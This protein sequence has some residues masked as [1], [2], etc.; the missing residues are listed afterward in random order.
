MEPNAGRIEEYR[1]LRAE[2]GA[3]DRLMQT[4]SLGM[5]FAMLAWAV[6][7][8]AFGTTSIQTRASG[9]A[10][11]LDQM[12]GLAE[13]SKAALPLVLAPAL[14]ACAYLQMILHKLE[15]TLRIAA[16]LRVMIEP[17][18]PGLAWETRLAGPA[19]PY[20]GLNGPHTFF[21][22]LG[23]G[24]SFW[25]GLLSFKDRPEFAFVMVALVFCL[26][27]GVWRIAGFRSATIGPEGFEAQFRRIAAR[28][29]DQA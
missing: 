7:Y 10:A 29:Q 12:V 11:M 21:L 18:V 6:G 15:G 26:A 19:S 14:L 24:A 17:H 23:L 20:H 28:E 2:I 13:L 25:A 8:V 16:Y 3:N 1:A 9:A 4:M 5:G 22:A 27:Y